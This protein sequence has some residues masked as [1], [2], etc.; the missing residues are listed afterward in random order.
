MARG[1]L[2]DAM[3]IR[4]SARQHGVGERVHCVHTGPLAACLR[5]ARGFI[6]ITSTSAFSAL[7]H[8]KVVVVLGRSVAGSNGV[9]FQEGTGPRRFPNEFWTTE[10]RAPA[11]SVAR[12]LDLIRTEALLPGDFYHP[13]GRQA[14]VRHCLDK[15]AQSASGARTSTTACKRASASRERSG[16]AA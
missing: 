2:A 8:G 6:T 15:L 12:L 1:H 16:K 9:T 13:V 3:Q 4:R 10:E 14:A 11:A 7:L 5:G